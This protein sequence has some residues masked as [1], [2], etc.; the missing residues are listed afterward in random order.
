M[1]ADGKMILGEVRADVR[2]EGGAGWGGAV[3]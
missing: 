3:I 1:D 2:M